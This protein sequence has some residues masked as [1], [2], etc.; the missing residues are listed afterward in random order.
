MVKKR[1]VGTYRI[2]EPPLRAT[3]VDSVPEEVCRRWIVE[4]PGWFES[5]RPS[6]LPGGRSRIAPGVG[7]GR[8]VFV[9]RQESSIG[10]TVFSAC[11]GRPAKSA[12]A[13]RL[14]LALSAAGVPT[15]RT[16]ALIERRG[17]VGKWES[18]LVLERLDACNLRQLVGDLLPDSPPSIEFKS[19]LV[20]SLAKSAA[21]LHQAGFRQR[22]LKAANLLVGDSDGE[23]VVHFVDFVGMRQ[24]WGAPPLRIRVRDI[25][26][27]SVSFQAEPFSEAG[28]DR[29][30][31]ESF[32]STY[33]EAFDGRPSST[34]ERRDVMELTERWA[35]RKIARNRRRR[36]P[37]S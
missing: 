24:F 7:H 37:I 20:K 18:C 31:W 10:R 5:P 9:K 8:E 21:A 28:F 33:L 13:F 35:G 26:R 34:E 30:D 19:K 15:A 12:R 4:Y 17:G 11:L 36:L 32:V 23:F 27:L 25:A 22:D 6:G 14:G 16:L 2:S 3:C 1:T 29:G